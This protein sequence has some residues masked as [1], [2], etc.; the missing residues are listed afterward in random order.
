MTKVSIREFQ[1]EDSRE[2]AKLHKESAESFE[3]FEVTEDFITHVAN[4]NDFRFFVVCKGNEVI[5]F[6]GFLFHVNVARAEMGPICVS[7][8]HRKSGVGTRLLDYAINFLRD[9][10]VQRITVRVKTNNRDA[11]DFFKGNGFVQEGYF[12]KYTARG[13]DVVQL[14]RFI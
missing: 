13:E 11:L 7:P 12:K 2:I 10:G 5:G 9:A 14:R 6:I 3:E 8:T 1:E 4:R